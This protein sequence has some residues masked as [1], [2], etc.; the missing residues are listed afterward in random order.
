MKHCAF[1]VSFAWPSLRLLLMSAFVL[2]PAHAQGQPRVYERAASNGVG[3]AGPGGYYDSVN[4][5]H[6][7]RG[8]TALREWGGAGVATQPDY[9]AAGPAALCEYPHPETPGYGMFWSPSMGTWS[10][11]GNWISGLAPADVP[12]PASAGVLR[13]QLAWDHAHHKAILLVET[14]TPPAVTAWQ[15]D[16]G[17]WTWSGLSV[18]S[19]PLPPGNDRFGGM[20]FDPTRGGV[21]ALTDAGAFLWDDV[22]WA[23]VPAPASYVTGRALAFDAARQRLVA[24]GGGS[25]LAVSNTTIEW[26]GTQW[27]SATPATSP[28]ARTGASLI[29]DPVRQQCILFGGTSAAG[30]VIDDI[31]GFDGTTWIDWSQP[32]VRPPALTEA[33]A[34]DITAGTFVFGGRDAS[35]N[36]T[37]QMWR[38]DGTQ[39]A[40]VTSTG[41]SP[42]PRFG[43]AMTALDPN[44]I[45]LFG[46]RSQNGT[47]FSDTWLYTA[48]GGWTAVSQPFPVAARYDAAIC[49]DGA[50]RAWLYGG[51][52]GFGAIGSLSLFDSVGFW[53]PISGLGFFNNVPREKG[54]LVYDRRTNKLV[55]FGG[56]NGTNP[57][58]GLTLLYDPAANL[59][60]LPP[61]TTEPA[62][63]DFA[64]AWDPVKERSVIVGGYDATIGLYHSAA[65]DWDGGPVWQISRIQPEL[66][67]VGTASCWRESTGRM[68]VFGGSSTI[69]GAPTA[70]TREIEHPFGDARLS[71]T[72]GY[73]AFLEITTSPVVTPQQLGVLGAR[74]WPA[75]SPSAGLAGLYVDFALAGQPFPQLSTPLFCSASEWTTSPSPAVGML[76]VG[77]PT[78]FALPLL[79]IT[80]GLRLVLQGLSVEA[81]GC[82]AVTQPMF[83]RVRTL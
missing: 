61:L 74:V 21:V 19:M 10:V 29:W 12:V 28:P 54:G 44:T 18:T 55:S 7:V 30:T 41:A 1:P 58:L 34:A 53:I 22:T 14:A 17:G 46:G 33:C 42:S 62:V 8:S 48:V 24:F 40:N 59:W 47:V 50:G 2:L 52:N 49:S 63:L 38:W 81:S 39:W 69:G 51:N 3:W 6:V 31:H 73:D 71:S 16:A 4:H 20:A 75:T 23:P 25:G 80:A 26:D 66:V 77:D 37:N 83:V 67:G 76:G 13:C 68:F 5:L 72:S 32:T 9:W 45:L 56:R 79:P 64:M 78:P 60:T 43:A 27:T 15:F 57:T 65:Q 36:A 35:G 82:I 11:F 70:R